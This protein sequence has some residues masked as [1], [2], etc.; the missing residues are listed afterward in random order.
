MAHA[1]AAILRRKQ[2]LALALRR[3]RSGSGSP[4][5]FLAARTWRSPFMSMG[6]DLDLHR[7]RT[8]FV[9][10]GGV[11]TA[12]YMPQRLTLDLD[13]LVAAEDAP[14][15]YEELRQAGCS[16]QGS[17]AI[18]GTTWQTPGGGSLDVLESLEP[19][20]RAAVRTPNRSAT[21]EPIVALPYLVL[22]KLAA[23]RPQDLADL[24]RMLGGAAE[25]TLDEVRH[26][27]ETYRGA[28]RDDL[29]SLITLGRLE[30]E[31]GQDDRKQ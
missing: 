22:L 19:W 11:A 5:E 20:A 18:G 26:I 27:V 8:P 29:E 7:L 12:L 4:R 15:F 14:A 16:R 9:I 23:S 25:A 6:I 3:A 10:V 31:A 13:V 24:S 17:L 21:G 30:F 1:D 28:D 2:F